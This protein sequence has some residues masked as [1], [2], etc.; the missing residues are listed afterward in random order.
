MRHPKVIEW[1]E[2]LKRVFDDIDHALEEKYR[3]HY[4]LHPAR[5]PQGA[6]SNPESDGLF[7][8][9]AAFSPGYGSEAGPGYI[10]EVRMATLEQVPADLMERIEEEVVQMLRERLP[11]AFP[12]QDLRVSRDGP[13]FKIHGDL[14][15]G[16][17]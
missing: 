16:E 1:E 8:V 10:V 15:L 3:G 4:T 6:T 9:G 7:N 13:V 14:S 17:V 12:G 2:K 5:P 11:R